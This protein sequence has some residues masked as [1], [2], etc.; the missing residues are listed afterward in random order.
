MAKFPSL[1]KEQLEHACEVWQKRLRLQDWDIDIE[2]CRHWEID[3][4]GSCR[5]SPELKWACIRIQEVSDSEGD[6]K[7]HYDM[8]HTLLHEMLHIQFDAVVQDYSHSIRVSPGSVTTDV[9]PRTIALEQAFCSITP[10][11]MFTGRVIPL[12]VSHGKPDR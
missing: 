6:T 1:T 10:W 5:V 9:S 2:V 3:S 11:L 4:Q 12:E 8:E 7:A